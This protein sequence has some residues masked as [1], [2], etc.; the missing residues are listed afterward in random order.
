MPEGLSLSSARFGREAVS[1][2]R[3]ERGP[4]WLTGHQS[5]PGVIADP[6][7][8]V[9]PFIGLSGRVRGE[10]GGGH[11]VEGTLNN[12]KGEQPRNA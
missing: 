5:T 3:K 1:E 9:Q 7:A 4:D 8:I 6:E 11:S 12:A 2:P 10:P